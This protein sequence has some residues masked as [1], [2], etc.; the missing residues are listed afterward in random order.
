IH[1]A[2]QIQSN[3]FEL[4]QFLRQNS[5]GKIALNTELEGRNFTPHTMELTWDAELSSFNLFNLNL[6]NLQSRGILSQ[7]QLQ[8]DIRLEDPKLRLES[9]AVWEFS[10]PDKPVYKT[11]TAVHFADLKALNL[12]IDTPIFV[13]RAKFTADLMGKHL[14]ALEGNLA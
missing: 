13:N 2:G 14:N 7:S 6:Y 10:D 3:G 11:S 9:T 5:I 4:G 1:Y 12:P 8:T